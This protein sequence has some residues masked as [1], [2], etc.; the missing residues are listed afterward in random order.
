M[1]IRIGKVWPPLAFNKTP[2]AKNMSLYLIQHARVSLQGKG[3]TSAKRKTTVRHSFSFFL[4]LVTGI[5]V[6]K[7]LMA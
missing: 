3:R 2:S 6:E 1:F 5:K 7:G 4:N